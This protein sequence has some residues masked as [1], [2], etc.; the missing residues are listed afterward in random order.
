LV[1]A[2]AYECIGIISVSFEYVIDCIICTKCDLDKCDLD[3]SVLEK[4]CEISYHWV[5]V[6]E[7]D[8]F[9]GVGRY[10]IV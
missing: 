7:G 3:I 6:Y 4:I 10:I 8:P 5:V 2:T 9:L 1:Y